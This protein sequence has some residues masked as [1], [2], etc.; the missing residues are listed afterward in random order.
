M[1]WRI[2]VFFLLES[3]C[4][5]T[6]AQTVHPA[7]YG[8]VKNDDT[9]SIGNMSEQVNNGTVRVSRPIVLGSAVPFGN[10]LHTVVRV[11][12]NGIILFGDGRVSVS[13][14]PDLQHAFVLKQD[15]IAPFWTDID[16]NEGKVYFGVFEKCPTERNTTLEERTSQVLE[17]AERDVERFHVSPHGFQA[18]T[19]IIATWV[20]VQPLANISEVEENTFQTVFVSGWH[21]ELRNGQKIWADE[22][23]SYVIFLYQRDGMNW[24]YTP[25]RVINIGFTNG[26]DVK[27]ARD[28]NTPLVS[29]LDKLRGNTGDVGVLSYKVGSVN[30][31]AAKCQ[32]Y[33]CE[34][35]YLMS[36]SVYDLNVKQLHN[37][38]CTLD[39][40]GLHWQLFEKRGEQQDI[41][42]YAISDVGK[43]KQLQNNNLNK[44]CCYKVE[45]LHPNDSWELAYQKLRS[46]SY[47]LS[48][49]DSGHILISDPWRGHEAQKNMQA[50][51]MCCKNSSKNMCDK[52]YTMFPDLG[53][54]DAVSF[55][56]GY[57][58]GDP[59]ITTFDG[60]T[61]TMNGWGEYIL[62][63]I[64]SEEFVL[65][66]RTARA[67][68]TNSEPTNATVFKAFAAKEGNNSHFQ[69]ELSP[70]NTSMIV[71]VNGIDVTQKYYGSSSFLIA[72][73]RINV[74]K[75]YIADKDFI[76]AIFPCGISIK[77]HVS[78]KNLQLEITADN[79]LKNRVEGLFG[80]FN[81][82]IKDE[83]S[84]ST[85]AYVTN[86]LN[87]KEIL[88]HIIK[89]WLVTPSNTIFSYERNKSPTDYKHED[90]IPMYSDQGN[91]TETNEICKNTSVTCMFDFLVTKDKTFA[92]MTQQFVDKMELSAQSLGNPPPKIS[93]ILLNAKNMWAVKGG[94]H[95]V[96][97]VE[98]T[99][100]DENVT[101]EPVFDLEE[102]KANISGHQ[103]FYLPDVNNP[104]KLGIRA[105]DIEGAYSAIYF[106]NI[107]VCS[108]C[109][110]HGK[111]DVNNTRTMDYI[112]GYFWI[113]KCVCDKGFTGTYCETKLD[114]CLVKPCSVGQVCQNLTITEQKNISSEFG[115]GCCPDGFEYY[116]G[117]CV[118]INECS[119]PSQVC[120]QICT[121]T[122]GS[123]LC[124]CKQGFRLGSDLNT[125]FDIN[126]CQD[127]TT[128]CQQRCVNN[129]G[130]YT[131]NSLHGYDIHI[132]SSG[133]ILL[134][135]AESSDTN[136]STQI[137][138]TEVDYLNITCCLGYS[139]NK[140]LCQ[141]I[142]ECSLDHSP[143]SHGCQNTNGSFFCFCYE[144]FMLDSDAVSC[145]KC[146]SPSYGVNCSQTCECSDNG[147]CD[148]VK[149]C[150]C[151]ENWTGVNCDV[152]VDECI[153]PDICPENQLCQ[154]TNGSFTCLCPTGFEMADDKCRDINE[155][156]E[157]EIHTYCDVDKEMCVN[158]VGSY[159]CRCNQGYSKINSSK[160]QDID[161]CHLATDQCQHYCQNV[162]GGYNCQCETG[163][164]LAEDRHNCISVTNLCAGTKLYCQMGCRTDDT[165][166]TYCF[167]P[168]GHT[169][170]NQS[171]CKDID[172]CSQPQNN[173]CSYK[174][175][176]VNT[177]GAYNCSCPPGQSLDNNGRTCLDCN[178]DTWGVQCSHE[179]ACGI[180]AEKCDPVS[181]CICKTGY[182]G[183]HCDR[184]INECASGRISCGTKEVCV[185]LPGNATCKCLAGYGF[186]ENG[187]CVDINE[188]SQ[189]NTQRCSQACANTVGG[190]ACFCHTGYSY[191]TTS[192]TCQ[193]IDECLLK[194]DQC[195]Q[196][197]N[198]TE[199]SY[200]CSCNPGLHLNYDGLTCKAD[201]SCVNSS[202][203][204]NL[205]VLI[206]GTETCFCPKG[207]VL[208][209]STQCEDVDLCKATPC[210]GGCL[211]IND[212]STYQ[213]ICEPGQSLALDGIICTDCLQGLYGANCSEQCTCDM[214]ST[215]HCDKING[216]CFCET[217]WMGDNCDQDIDEC[218]NNSSMCQANSSCKNTNGSFLCVCDEGFSLKFEGIKICEECDEGFYGQSC[219]ARCNCG[220]HQMC[221]KVNGSCSCVPGWHGGNCEQDVDECKDLTHGC[222]TSMHEECVNVA[223]GFNCECSAGFGR[224][225]EE[226]YC[227][228]VDLCS[229]NKCEEVCMEINSNTSVKCL[230]QAGKHLAMDDI[231][232]EDCPAWKFGRDCME[233][234]QCDVSNTASCDKVYGTC[235][236]RDGWEGENCSVDVDE[237]I[238]NSSF[239][240]Q[241]NSHCVNTNGSSYCEC[242][243][244]FWD[245][246]KGAIFCEECEEGFYGANCSQ[247]CKCGDHYQCD[248]VNGSCHCLPYWNGS[249]CNVDVNECDI[250]TDNCS[251]DLH[252]Q[253]VNIDGGFNCECQPGFEKSCHFCE[254]SD[255]DLCSNT[256]CTNG[257]YEINANSSFKCLC[258]DGEKIESDGKSCSECTEWT[259]GNMCS[260]NCT[261]DTSNTQSW[262]K[263]NGTCKCKQGWIG[264]N[265]ETDVNECNE[266][267]FSCGNNT[268]CVNT[269]GSYLCECDIGYINGSDQENQCKECNKWKYGKMCGYDCSCEISNTKSCDNVNGTCQ[270][271]EGW[272]GD[273]CEMDID[274][275]RDKNITCW[276]NSHCLNTNGSYVCQC[277][278]GFLMSKNLAECQE[279]SQ[280]TYGDMCNN[281]CTCIRNNSKSCNKE[282][283]T[284]ECIMGWKGDNCQTDVD[285]CSFIN[286]LCGNNS[287]CHNTDGSYMCECNLGYFAEDKENGNCKACYMWNYEKDCTQ[288]CTCVTPNTKTCDHITGTCNC[289][290]GWEGDD[291]EKDLDECSGKSFTCR[292]NSHCVNTNGSYFCECDVGFF[293]GNKEFGNCDECSQWT[294][295]DM[296]K[297]NCTCIRNNSISCNKVNG[298]CECNEGWKR[299]NC[300]TDVDECSFTN[301]LC[302]N[303]SHCHNTDGSYMCECNLGYFVENEEN[304]NCSTCYMWNYGKYCTQNCTCV[305]SNTNTCDNINGTC[306]CKQGWKG[307]NCETDIDECSGQI[308]TC[309][310]NSN[311]VN[312]NGS[313]SCVCNVGYFDGN[314]QQGDCKDCS[315]WKFGNNCQENCNCVTENTQT[316]D[317]A[318]G[319]CQC[320]TGWKGDNCEEDIN[321]CSWKN[322][323]CRN[324]SNCVNTNGSYL[325]KCDVGF[326]DGNK[327]YGDCDE[328]SQWKYG[329]QCNNS[330]TC[331]RNNTMFCNKVNGTCDCKHGWK[332][333][334]CETDINECS[335]K[336]FTCRNNSHC[337][338]TNGSYSC[339]CNVGYFDGNDQQ[340]DCKACIMWNYGKDC[341]QNCTCVPSNTNYCDNINGTCDCKQG[342]TGFNCDTDVDECKEKIYSCRNNSH[343][344]NTNGFYL[345][346]CLAGYLDD[347]MQHGDCKVCNQWKY[348]IDCKQN[349]TCITSNTKY[350]DNVNGT[351]ECL[352]GWSGKSC[353]AD[354]DE[355]SE[356]VFMCKKNSYCF[357]TN[358]SY[359]CTCNVGYSKK[360]NEDGDCEVCHLWNYSENCNKSCS[361][362][363]PNTE[364]CDKVNGTCACKEGWKG[365]NCETDID[366]CLI[367]TYSCRNNS[368]CV[369][370][371]G[372]YVCE[373]DIGFFDGIDQNQT[374]QG[375]SVWSYGEKCKQNC[376][377]KVSNT[378]TCENVHGT[379]ACKLGWEGDDCETD[380]DECSRNI[381]VC[382]ESSHCVNTDGHY[383]CECDIGYFHGN[384]ADGTCQACKQW[385]YG[386]NCIKKC[387][388]E[389]EHTEFCDH[390]NGT[391]RCNA[392]WE[393]KNCELDVDECQIQKNKCS[394]ERHELCSNT[395]GGYKCLCEPGFSRSFPDSECEKGYIQSLP[396]RLIFIYDAANL[397]LKDQSSRDF[398][399]V[400]KDLE[401]NL[402][403]KL[404][405]HMPTVITVTVISLSKGSLI[406]DCI[407]VLRSTVPS[408]NQTINF[409][410]Q[411]LFSIM[412]N[413]SDFILNNQA[414]R[415]S[416][417]VVNDYIKFNQTDSPCDLRSKLFPCLPTEECHQQGQETICMLVVV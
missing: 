372:S 169:M 195:D 393:G 185:N 260:K 416:Q 237:C 112:N 293:D 131:C 401:T 35:L 63:T 202:K 154:N 176:C 204:S 319:T 7:L 252:Q 359:Q 38:P 403:S 268:H 88:N 210:Q 71:L 111:C 53:C 161:E 174:E 376:S 413:E 81:G 55:T 122:I 12:T 215:K 321:E 43:G 228:D 375:C 119:F 179:C 318:N 323:T 16:P 160:C 60:L 262:D 249:N 350:C 221:N 297:N 196:M 108:E 187:T 145:R 104:V 273:N 74:F 289:K 5:Y 32:R 363:F 229:P 333:D 232:C 310:N 114:A 245:L 352:V 15:V 9:L 379:C 194:L 206:N 72:E 347:G 324:N 8:F 280:W 168:K 220:Q 134:L 391:C 405:N 399:A 266:N 244:G 254:C 170:Y 412:H 128:S 138:N 40:L 224:S 382:K 123:Y 70:S 355:C 151:D 171:K 135:D 20:K 336:M 184:D 263:V 284:C 338:N 75:E 37:C 91:H 83:Y 299:D 406:S 335:E 415:M 152:D 288:N 95:A 388:C 300:Q 61:Y 117:K 325:C 93:Q 186:D 278:T 378:E 272:K 197:C 385:T 223:G 281:N 100:D 309:R 66:T 337:V 110:H 34:N 269:N 295:G 107:A 326:F 127:M 417:V 282:N 283:G 68:T 94:N 302:G 271:N 315:E 44:L 377:C 141:D 136:H 45:Q 2:V 276:S 1:C 106:I 62:M 270:C 33:L 259:F 361:C 317:K 164:I 193:D 227:Q 274:E 214:M 258:N 22:Q 190:F 279:C 41:H 10:K 346:D 345:C 256:S 153:S 370:S 199:G 362:V 329:D 166:Q 341:Y 316:C 178:N 124:S 97:D 396:T 149:G 59:H 371:N 342:W 86:D 339:V 253:C 331:I 165:N 157:A 82:L 56:H 65:Q 105:K 69:V 226:N 311:C 26:I 222:N 304:G 265:C 410:T 51:D 113:M 241:N 234:C 358:G 158:T 96:L 356:N 380:V 52:F 242:D 101:L 200:R 250:G 285:E 103:I 4:C 307:D 381:Y 216:T 411:A 230:C 126:E 364:T 67:E 192:N 17:R 198:N 225:N 365:D 14:S 57:G 303:N 25:G 238:S 129:E 201:E 173:G 180:G 296:C 137:Y 275:C 27:L 132:D 294:Y 156:I 400:S 301:I 298:T 125:C 277:H 13:G 115:C 360:E 287:H 87:E 172:E 267:I 218:A 407:V 102:S 320:R 348:G 205:C 404:I 155:C 290:Q 18:T 46:S 394:I 39:R 327:D 235:D 58:Y 386:D 109:S 306:D 231:S 77:V 90:F 251:S 217:G 366:E 351:C 36:D 189:M 139:E 183:K 314:D 177:L 84:E 146:D 30:T 402:M 76:T 120:H 383:I 255:L 305:T 147:Y 182:T 384:N 175:G 261:C 92:F 211:E 140:G 99:D 387:G 19:V 213:C 344:V 23:T 239:S 247:Q 308:V 212:N 414:A 233:H 208:I 392:P 389:L 50:H 116:N 159:H 353:E 374:C 219:A 98:V 398:Q 148:V 397:N 21:H 49:P 143:C 167:C 313:Y 409:L 332:G 85:G 54:S 369:N 292:N 3:Q 291:C 373:C 24:T 343:C 368:H 48:S 80:N 28:T 349:C 188:C 163:Y 89:N 264:Q 6:S 312:I 209:N 395:K 181:G 328:C 334:N 203:C 330:C 248:K 31:S 390:V 133:C 236:C 142:D 162:E 243:D 286:I 64:E 11:L 78:Q 121:N 118:D 130:S 73:R 144:G 191:N 29:M 322:V 47:L 79:Y 367:K 150:V 408:T 207:K 340:G 354:I 42:C 246:E 257:C 240:C 357:N